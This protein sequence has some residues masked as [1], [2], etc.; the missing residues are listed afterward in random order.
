VEIHLE[1]DLTVLVGENDSGKTSIV[2]ALKIMFEDKEAEIDDFYGDTYEIRIEVELSD[3]SFIKEFSKDNDN[4][5]QSKNMVRFSHEFLERI[6]EDINSDDFNLLLEGDKRVRLISYAHTLGIPFR[7]NIGTDTL[8]D[9]I[10]ENIQELMSNE[11]AIEGNI[12][13]YNIYFLDGKHFESISEFFQEIFFKE[14]SREIWH[15]EV[16]EGR[17]IEDLIKKNLDEYTKKLKTEI[18]EKG[19][20]D[21]LKSFLPELTEISVKP[22]FEPRSINIG[23]EVQLL[24]DEDRKIRVEKKGDGTKRRITMALLEYEKAKEEEPSLYVFDEPDTHL[25][26]KAQVDLLN[27]VRQFNKGE[28]QV[29]IV[30]HSPFIMNSVKPRQI[31][32]LSLEHGKTKIKPI[33]TSEDVEWT[34]K[35]LGI[36][37]INLFFSRKILLVEGETE[38]RFISLIYEKLFDSSLYS[39]LVKVI[40]RKSITD[41]PR[42]AEV[43]SKFVKPEGIFILIDNDAEEETNDIIKKL[44]IPEENVFVVGRKE[45]E[46][47]FEAEVI[48]GAWKRFIENKGKEIGEEW[49]IEHIKRLRDECIESGE[50]FSEK[51]RNLNKGCLESM[52]KPKFAQALAEYCER[53]DLPEEISKLLERLR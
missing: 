32:L 16:E 13:I 8:K 22:I 44:K 38:E 24:E 40:N 11:D 50:K 51:L 4:N 48:Y 41:V 31:R 42:F 36:E 26:V 15:E 1:D 46:D 21:K 52:K 28:K 29:I 6:R 23:V 49:T 47:A 43:L 25:H 45:F 33:S 17:T 12:P 2:D 39:I 27:I 5:I 14:K 7:A 10:V 3:R 19:I 35:S 53:D 37:N 9:R 34:L 30:T 18:E 20:K